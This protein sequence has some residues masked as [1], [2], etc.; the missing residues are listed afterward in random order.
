MKR[1]LSVLCFVAGVLFCTSLFAGESC[2]HQI[3]IRIIHP[4]VFEVQEIQTSDDSGLTSSLTWQPG[5]EAKKV[6]VSTSADSDTEETSVE[7]I[8]TEPNQSGTSNLFIPTTADGEA[9]QVIAYTV[10]DAS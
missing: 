5:S 9:T 3:I 1:M 7:L 8:V 4:Q 6:T 2:S 10:T